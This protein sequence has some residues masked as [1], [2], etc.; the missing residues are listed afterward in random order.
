MKRIHV[1]K[2]VI[3]SNRKHGRDEPPIAVRQYRDAE[4]KTPKHVE[5]GHE[6][7]LLDRQGAVVA[8]FIYDPENPLLCGARLWLETELEVR[9]EHRVSAELGRSKFVEA[10]K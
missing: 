6:V 7:E 5:Y 9:V 4:V 1:N 10:D 3:A 2:H 8:R